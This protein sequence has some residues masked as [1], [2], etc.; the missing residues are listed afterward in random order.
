MSRR[1]KLPSHLG[2][3]GYHRNQACRG[4]GEQT[5]AGGA[6]KRNAGRGRGKGKRVHTG[7]H[8]ESL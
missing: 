4:R 8:A 2:H 1:Q 6:N 3:Q 7:D 5:V